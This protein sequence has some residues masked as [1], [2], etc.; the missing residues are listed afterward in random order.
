MDII[1]FSL[2][3]SHPMFRNDGCD[4]CLILFDSQDY[5]R[6]STYQRAILQNDVDFRDK[7]RESATCA[8][9]KK[10]FVAACA[11]LGIP[12]LLC[13]REPCFFFIHNIVGSGASILHDNRHGAAIFRI[14]CVCVD[15]QFKIVPQA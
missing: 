8:V 9:H 6:T 1:Y 12:R 11:H 10:M 14:T 13:A 3:L 2:F 4:S 15:E 7:V 5:T